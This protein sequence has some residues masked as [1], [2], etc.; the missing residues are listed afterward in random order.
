MLLSDIKSLFSFFSVCI[1]SWMM[2]LHCTRQKRQ[3]MIECWMKPMTSFKSNWQNCNPAMPS[4]LSSWSLSIKG[5]LDYRFLV[6]PDM[7]EKKLVREWNRPEWCNLKMDGMMTMGIEKDPVL[8]LVSVCE[9]AMV[10]WNGHVDCS[11]LSY[12]RKY[13]EAGTNIETDR[14]I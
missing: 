13:F 6:S 3:K 1:P 12:L 10:S 11:K 5:W 8:P 9:I 4:V 7:L 2:L 14:K